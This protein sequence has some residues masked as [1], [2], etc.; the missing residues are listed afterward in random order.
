[1]LRCKLLQPFDDPD[2]ALAGVLA[3]RG[4]RLLVAGT[5]IGRDG[6][7]Y[8]GKFNQHRALHQTLFHRLR[9]S[10]ASQ[11]A[12]A[13]RGQSRSRQLGIGGERV[14]IGN[15][16]IG[17]DPKTLDHALLLEMSCSDCP[18]LYAGGPNGCEAESTGSGPSAILATNRPA[19]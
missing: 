5:V 2:V 9:G 15:G 10:A 6:L 16:T 18:R 3:E 11:K 7:I 19:I 13:R 14:G 4:K 12:S 8:A 17:G 1:M